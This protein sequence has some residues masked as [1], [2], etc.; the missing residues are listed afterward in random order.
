M[1]SFIHLLICFYLFAWDKSVFLIL[2]SLG[3]MLQAKL[4]S[5]T[6]HHTEYLEVLHLGKVPFYID[7]TN[8]FG[9]Q[10]IS[11]MFQSI[12]SKVSKTNLL[13]LNHQLGRIKD[14]V[15]SESSQYIE[16]FGTDV[17]TVSELVKSESNKINEQI[18]NGRIGIPAVLRSED[19]DSKNNQ[20]IVTE[21][22]LG[23]AQN[24]SPVYAFVDEGRFVDEEDEFLDKN[25][26]T[27]FKDDSDSEKSESDESQGLENIVKKS[28]TVKLKKLEQRVRSALDNCKIN[29]KIEAEDFRVELQKTNPL[30]D[31]CLEQSNLSDLKALEETLWS[32]II[33]RNGKLLQL[34]EDK[35][36]LELRNAEG[37]TDVKDLVSIMTER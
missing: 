4:M 15:L 1:D 11:K 9:F 6:K 33:D 36:T 24:N 3:I 32:T 31:I 12:K 20:E 30:N 7:T 29:A 13:D 14:T 17:R 8:N 10:S 22:R 21:T 26:F 37:L 27:Y 19:L 23:Q 5:M 16:N 34:I 35:E 2:H 25:V 28:K 18:F